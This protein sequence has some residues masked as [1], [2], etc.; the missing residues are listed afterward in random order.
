MDSGYSKHITGYLNILSNVKDNQGGYVAFAGNQGGM[1]IEE[2]N[3]SNG[4]FTFEK[5]N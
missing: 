1:I 4:S 5:V 2:G 3:V